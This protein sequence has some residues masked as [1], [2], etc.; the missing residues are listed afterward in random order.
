M[1]STDELHLEIFE[2][3]SLQEIKELKTV[4]H[5]RDYD[6]GETVLFQNQP[7]RDLYIVAQGEVEIT[8]LPYDGPELRVGRLSSGGVFGWSSILGRKAYTSTVK[9][10]TQ[11]RL[12]CLPSQKLQKFCELH[13]ETGVVLLEKIA[14]SVAQNPDGIHEQIMQM[15][16]YTMACGEGK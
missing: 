5:T 9:A 3:F 10:V 2:D 7:A 1:L 6:P 4:I 11:C 15:I 16:R 14:L 8:H 13:H 12:F